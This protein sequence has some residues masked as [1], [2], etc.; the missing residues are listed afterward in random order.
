MTDQELKEFTKKRI[1]KLKERIKSEPNSELMLQER[2]A[3][4][5]DMLQSF[6]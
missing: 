3:I 2:L 5:E 6:K 4:Y 1:E